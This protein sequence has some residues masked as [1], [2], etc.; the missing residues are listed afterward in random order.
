[1]KSK[2]VQALF[3]KVASM[4]IDKE[5][6]GAALGFVGGISF[7]VCEAIFNNTLEMVNFTQTMTRMVALMGIAYLVAMWNK[8]RM[9]NRWSKQYWFEKISTL[10]A[11][12]V[13]WGIMP[14]ILVY[15][16]FVFILLRR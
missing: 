4:P 16:I 8:W 7:W 3:Q 11:F 5:W 13:V 12:S 14:S 9:G 10:L 6:F 2:K 15:N 1:M